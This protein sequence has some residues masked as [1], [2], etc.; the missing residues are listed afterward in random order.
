MPNSSMLPT[1]P[2]VPHAQTAVL[3]VGNVVVLQVEPPLLLL[4]DPLQTCQRSVL[5]VEACDC[6]EQLP[7]Q[8]R[9]PLRQVLRG[10][11]PRARWALPLIPPARQVLEREVRSQT[12]RFPRPVAHRPLVE[13]HLRQ[14]LSLLEGLPQRSPP[15]TWI[16]DLLPLPRPHSFRISGMFKKKTNHPLLRHL[17]HV[18]EEDHLDDQLRVPVHLK[19]ITST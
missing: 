2:Q 10:P 9:S 6:P 1:C 8:P 12:S 11:I 14:A 19:F 5:L 15:H 3:P 4:A 7:L 17:R 18:V 13:L 16:V